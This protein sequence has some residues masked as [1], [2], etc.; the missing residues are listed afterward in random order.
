MISGIIFISIALAISLIIN[1]IMFGYAKTTLARINTVYRASESSAEIFSMIDA[2]KEHLTTVYEMPTFYGD[3][4]LKSLLDHSGELIEYLKGYENIYSFTQPELEEQL[5]Q[6]S[7]DLND[8]QEEE[9]A[10]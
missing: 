3:D 5:I 7:D 9:T 2:F 1:V 8:D 6:A 10:A 4:T